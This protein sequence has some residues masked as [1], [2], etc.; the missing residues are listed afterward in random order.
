MWCRILLH[1]CK[2]LL[3]L[4]FTKC[5]RFRQNSQTKGHRKYT[6]ETSADHLYRSNGRVQTSHHFHD[7]TTHP[8]W[9][10][11]DDGSSSSAAATDRIVSRWGATWPFWA[12]ANTICQSIMHSVNGDTSGQVAYPSSIHPNFTTIETQWTAWCKTNLPVVCVSYAWV[13]FMS[14]DCRPTVRLVNICIGGCN[15]ISMAI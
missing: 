4:S 13:V 6:N 3:W 8:Q 15:L 2:E 11:L 5:F 1:N 14:S 10:A 9:A 12:A 7:R